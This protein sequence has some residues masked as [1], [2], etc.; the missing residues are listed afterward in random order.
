MPVG[1][2]NPDGAGSPPGLFDE[3]ERKMTESAGGE[4]LGSIATPGA[5]KLEAEIAL[6]RSEVGMARRRVELDTVRVGVE[7]AKLVVAALGVAGAVAV[8]LQTLG[9]VGAGG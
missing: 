1:K 3:E 9:L 4:D 6:T 8:A 5:R 7:T 2:L